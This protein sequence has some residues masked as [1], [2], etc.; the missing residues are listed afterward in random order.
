M[1]T[2]PRL[3]AVPSTL[4]IPLAARAHGDRCFPQ[5]A[6]HDAVA[7]GL[8]ERLGADPQAWLD[9]RLTVLNVLWR[10]GAI[11]EAAR[12]FFA[13]HPQATGANLGCG[14]SHY[15][16]WLD[17]GANQWVDADLSEVMNLRTPLLPPCGPRARH[18]EVDIA[19]PGWWR[20]LGLPHADEGPGVQPV[21]V[22]CEGVLMYLE[23]A[24]VRAVLRE[25]ARCA[26]PGSRMVLDVLTR[27]AVGH[28]GSHPSVG[29]TGA[30]F[31]WGVGH[32]AELAD[33]HPRLALLH[34]QSVSE[35]YGWLGMALETLWM[36]WLGAPMYGVATLGVAD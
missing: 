26:P 34:G 20:R 15:F 21:L 2:L 7:R 33:A 23:P 5:L 12:A 24:Q 17:T 4:L 3:H 32:T 11:K 6:C 18:A 9:D 13:A 16:Q 25:F 10:T 1:S 19:R 29:P 28:A 35:C 27:W 8:L 14:L 36:P 31:R 30:E 22:V